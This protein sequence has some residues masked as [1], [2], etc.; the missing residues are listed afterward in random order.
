MSYPN[1]FEG[2]SMIFCDE[3]LPEAVAFFTS[4]SGTRQLR[5]PRK[6]RQFWPCQDDVPFHEQ[7]TTRVLR[8]HGT[9]V[10]DASQGTKK[11]AL[12]IIRY[13]CSQ[14]VNRCLLR[15]PNLRSAASDL[16]PIMV[17]TETI[18][19][20]SGRLMSHFHP[21]RIGEHLHA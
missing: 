14:H 1:P 21:I 7:T 15:N 5:S 6:G 2:D 12:S 3:E 19:S 10:I 17:A 8:A 13:T 4:T 20:I 18:R 16:T 9:G 11:L